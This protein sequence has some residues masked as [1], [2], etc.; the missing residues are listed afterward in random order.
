MK[1]FKADFTEDTTNLLFFQLGD[2]S[3]PARFVYVVME[4]HASGDAI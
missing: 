2:T 3:S 1:I 4:T